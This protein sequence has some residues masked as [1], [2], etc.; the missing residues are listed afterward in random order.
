MASSKATLAPVRPT[1]CSMCRAEHS[2]ARDVVALYLPAA[3]VTQGCPATGYFSTALRRL[4]K[5]V[6]ALQLHPRVASVG[7]RHKGGKGGGHSV[8]LMPHPT[9]FTS[10]SAPM[11]ARVP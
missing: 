2:P 5:R 4:P 11:Q 1:R 9:S 8:S 3:E 10:T 6:A 7:V